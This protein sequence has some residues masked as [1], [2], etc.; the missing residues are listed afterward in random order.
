MVYREG[1]TTAITQY[2]VFN[3]VF[4]EGEDTL[5]FEEADSNLVE[6]GVKL[7]QE[8]TGTARKFV[9]EL[10]QFDIDNHYAEIIAGFTVWPYEDDESEIVIILTTIHD[11]L[12]R[13]GFL[14]DDRYY[15]G[16]GPDIR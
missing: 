9:L 6:V 2:Y 13:V 14:E 8:F 7:E 10:D 5:T 16:D 1:I 3:G 4:R 12:E 15:M 11:E